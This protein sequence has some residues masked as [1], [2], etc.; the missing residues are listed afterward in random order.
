MS[1]YY[2]INLVKS[3]AVNVSFTSS[4]IKY[5]VMCE[6][7]TESRQQPVPC[8]MQPRKRSGHNL[9]EIQL[10]SAAFFFSATTLVL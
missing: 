8:K 1:G 7:K 5:D 9:Q 4:T 10:I 6:R 2:R 3:L